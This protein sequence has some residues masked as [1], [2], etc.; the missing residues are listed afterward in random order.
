[1]NATGD[2][3]APQH[4]PQPDVENNSQLARRISLPR[5][6]SFASAKPSQTPE[7]V[8]ADPAPQPEPA[9]AAPTHD[10]GFQWRLT[11]TNSGLVARDHMAN[12]RT[13]L[14]W[15]RTALV[16][17]TLGVTFMQMYS[18]HARAET[19]V[20]E[21]KTYTLDQTSGVRALQQVGKPLGILLGAFSIIVVF[22]GYFRYLRVQQLLQREEFPATR[23]IALTV[24]VMS[25][26]VMAFVLALDI[27]SSV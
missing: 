23:V 13:F 1:M 19:V 8:S 17:A 5:R 22:F 3:S 15:V 27:R 16:M 4:T 12:E 14:A 2:Q 25:V 21:N 18:I 9:P 24:V 26:T 11:L 6:T 20:W 7:A 10:P